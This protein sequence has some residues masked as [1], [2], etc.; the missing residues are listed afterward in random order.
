VVVSIL[1]ILAM[2]VTMNVVGITT[3][4]QTRATD[5]EHTTVQ[6]A[7]DAMLGDK[8]IS[9]TTAGCGSGATSN[10]AAF[11]STGHPL[12][13]LYLHNPAATRRPYSC[14]ANGQITP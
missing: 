5:S 10:M 2:I 8:D 11:P 3:K 1:G 14:D 7:L 13:P 12:N 6:A 4:A 9:A